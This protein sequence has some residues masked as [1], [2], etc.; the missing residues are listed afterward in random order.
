MET[1]RPT[2]PIADEWVK[3]HFDH[4]SPDL[5]RELHPTLA[6]A[7]ALCPVAR[8]DAHGG[9]WV[10]T[11]YSDLLRTLPAGEGPTSG[12]AARSSPHRAVGRRGPPCQ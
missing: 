11:R 5:A 10:A 1:G 9:F 3:R 2:F 12:L 6:R 8:S 7:R 4:L